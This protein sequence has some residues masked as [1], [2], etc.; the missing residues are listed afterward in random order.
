MHG[1]VVHAARAGAAIVPL[2]RHRFATHICVTSQLHTGEASP[3]SPATPT[4]PASATLASATP[5]R[6]PHLRRLP[7]PR[8]SAGAGRIAARGLGAARHDGR[9]A[10]RSR[11]ANPQKVFDAGYFHDDRRWPLPTPAARLSR[12]LNANPPPASASRRAPARR[13][14]VPG[15]RRM[16]RLAAEGSG[17]RGPAHRS[18]SPEVNRRRV[19]KARVGHHGEEVGG[20]AD[21]GR[22]GDSGD[23]RPTNRRARSYG[24]PHHRVSPV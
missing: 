24:G 20:V 3:A 2:S 4:S 18:E 13:R 11:R 21:E 12:S 5:P 6:R 17:P 22:M 16:K 10:G 9:T 7:G 15:V 14:S 23:M 8:P 19:R 1:G